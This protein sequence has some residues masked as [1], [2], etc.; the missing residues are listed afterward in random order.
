[1]TRPASFH[2]GMRAAPHLAATLLFL[3]LVVSLAEAA[4]A[5]ERH[6]IVTGRDSFSIGDGDIKSETRYAGTEVLTIERHGKA[7][8]YAARVTYRRDDQGATSD[9]TAD[10]VSDLLPTG[11][12]LDSADRDP[13]YLTV[14]NQPFAAQLDAGTL[15]DLKRMHG[16]VPF[17]F[18]SPFAGAPLRGFLAEAKAG[19][20]AGRHAIGVKFSA[21]GPM[22]GALPDRP[23]ITLTGGIIMRGTAYYDADTALLL[24][25]DATVTISGNVSNR[26]G[27]DPVTIVY[28][29]II[30]AAQ[31]DK[32][33]TADR[34]R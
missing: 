3:A 17:D 31:P 14:L 27:K 11:E 29:R 13:D 24:T 18:P 1:M 21:G 26:S 20:V 7:M 12:Q 30:K 19:V 10:Y 15:H 33:S 32:T 6:Y 16:A 22:N 23:G 28:R 5:D 25:L 9:A 4:R 8:R 2:E 34:S